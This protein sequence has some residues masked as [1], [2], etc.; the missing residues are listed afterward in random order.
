MPKLKTNK[1]IKKRFKISKNGKVQGFPSLHRHMMTDRSSKKRRQ[2]RKW[3]TL[4]KTDQR[5]LKAGL[6]YQA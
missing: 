6:P 2:S 5:R 1:A 3:R 4:G